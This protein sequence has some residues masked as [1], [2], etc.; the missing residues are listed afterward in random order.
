M[1]TC[2]TSWQT[3]GLSTFSGGLL[4]S[5]V[6]QRT[7]S[8]SGALCN[9]PNYQRGCQTPAMQL[10]ICEYLLSRSQH[11]AHISTALQPA[12]VVKYTWPNKYIQRCDLIEPQKFLLLNITVALVIAC[13]FFLYNGSIVCHHFI[14]LSNQLMFNFDGIMN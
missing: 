8:S 14:S 10:H 3:S 5:A 2:T 7:L 1:G 12:L 6:Y 13:D 9:S 11:Y 4:Q